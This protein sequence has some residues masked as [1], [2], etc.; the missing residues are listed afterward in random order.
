MLRVLLLTGQRLSE[1]AGMRWDELDMPRATWALDRTRV[2]TDK[3]FII[4]LAPATV[5]L[6]EALPRTDDAF[7]FPGRR[8]GCPISTFAKAKAAVDKA[9]G[10]HGWRIHDLRRT[11][12]TNLSRLEIDVS[13]AELCIGHALPQMQGV[14]DR[15]DRMNARREAM[16]A[17]A[18]MLADIVNPMPANVI[19]L[20]GRI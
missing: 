11:V 7:V 16:T 5:R 19:R 10:V 20:A 13:V 9:S 1:V 18:T 6:I 4:P 3:A 14:Y 15:H 2:K 12:R 17:W 8:G